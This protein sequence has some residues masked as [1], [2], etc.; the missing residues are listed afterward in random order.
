MCGRVEK[1]S[2]EELHNMSSYFPHLTLKMRLFCF[3]DFWW[4]LN[5]ICTKFV[6][7]L[8]G[9]IAAGNEWY[10]DHFPNSCR[11][12]LS[13]ASVCRHTMVV[14]VSNIWWE[15]CNTSCSVSRVLGCHRHCAFWR[16]FHYLTKLSCTSL[17]SRM[18]KAKRQKTMTLKMVQNCVRVTLDN[19]RSLDLSLKQIS[20]V[21]KCILKLCDMNELNL[22]RNLIKKMPSFIY[23]FTSI[24]V[25]D[26]HSNYVSMTQTCCMFVFFIIWMLWNLIKGLDVF[27]HNCVVHWQ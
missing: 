14:N 12:T 25:L 20:T 13:Y 27:L 22:S 8:Y 7:D 18:S 2:P 9:R 21:P 6:L 3:G 24:S 26:L 4:N 19:K 5:L 10:I 1:E 15:L 16:L 23:E 17:C 11:D